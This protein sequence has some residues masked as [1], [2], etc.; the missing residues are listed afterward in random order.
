MRRD[1][2][3]AA[4]P[5]SAIVHSRILNRDCNPGMPK[6]CLVRGMAFK[7]V[8]S[9][10]I[11]GGAVPAPLLRADKSGRTVSA[12]FAQAYLMF[13]V[14]HGF[15]PQEMC[16]AAGIRPLDIVDR[17]SQVPYEWVNALGRQLIE[18]L[19]HLALGIELGQFIS[20]SFDHTYVGQAMLNCR[21]SLEGIKLLARSMRLFDSGYRRGTSV[22]E[23]ASSIEFHAP[24]LREDPHE[25]I[26]MCFVSMFTR[27]RMHDARFALCEVRFAHDREPALRRRFGELLGCPVHFDCAANVL[28][29]ERELV[30]RPIAGADPEA[31][32]HFGAHVAKLLDGLD[33]PFVTLVTR[34]IES[35][36]GRD[37]PSQD[38]V[39]KL[40]GV[41]TRSLRRALHDHG[42]SYKELLAATRRARA[43]S[44][45]ANRTIAIYE[46]ALALSY[47]DVSTFARAFRQW[48]GLSPR[49]F[50]EASSS[51]VRECSGQPAAGEKARGVRA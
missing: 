45:L 51:I 30:E 14:K 18:R 36:L 4:L 2:A 8:R 23:L 29:I 15:D 34:A 48:T 24:I 17:E 25:V 50:R 40:L 19:P 3:E 35:L 13:G 27:A 42:A 12:L 7:A 44:L 5:A 20:I 38:R 46:V 32:A 11:S 26:E 28:A 33:E 47:D 6:I 22:I 16:A 1:F 41:S 39:A 9:Q 31:G 21:T 49:D 43:E 10:A 37:E